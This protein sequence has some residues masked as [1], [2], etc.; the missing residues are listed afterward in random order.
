MVLDLKV[1]PQYFVNT[2]GV[3]LDLLF[4]PGQH[5]RIKLYGIRQHKLSSGQKL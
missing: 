1:P 2:L 4:E 3:I 5:L